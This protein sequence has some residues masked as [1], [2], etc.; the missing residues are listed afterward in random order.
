MKIKITFENKVVKLALWSYSI[1]DFLQPNSA[2]NIN[3]MELLYSTWLL[4]QTSW[5]KNGT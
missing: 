3:K 5:A 1:Q 4:N 2:A